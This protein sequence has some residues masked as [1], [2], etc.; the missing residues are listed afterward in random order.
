MNKYLRLALGLLFICGCANFPV[1]DNSLEMS[2]CRKEMN[3][4]VALAASG[5]RDVL[6]ISPVIAL[7]GSSL[8]LL[9]GAA[10]FANFMRSRR[11]I[12]SITKA[13]EQLE[14]T[15]AKEVKQAILRQVLEDKI[16]DYVHKTVKRDL[17]N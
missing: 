9:L 11:A 14:P 15:R 7:S 5:N 6:N 3:N 8:F 16:A 10:F 4:R 17:R 13:I 1:R 12:K 2:G